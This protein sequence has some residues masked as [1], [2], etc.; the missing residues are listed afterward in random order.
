MA[1]KAVVQ[2][3]I[4]S[5]VALYTII[6]SFERRNEETNRVIGTLMGANDKGRVEVKTCFCVPHHESQDEVGFS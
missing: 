1:A 6:D 4:V 5:P 2:E 3:V